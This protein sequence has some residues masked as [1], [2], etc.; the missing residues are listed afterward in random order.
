MGNCDSTIDN[1]LL[2]NNSQKVITKDYREFSSHFSSS[3]LTTLNSDIFN[4]KDIPLQ[5]KK[6][7]S[8]KNVNPL[9]NKQYLLS[10]SISKREDI[11]KK[12]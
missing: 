9:E 2:K 3:S 4:K 5:H 8:T 11:T 6:N 7:N 10:E 1:H 12:I